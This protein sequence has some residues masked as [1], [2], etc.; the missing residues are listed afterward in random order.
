MLWASITL[1]HMVIDSLSTQNY[2]YLNEIG[3]EAVG[4][5]VYTVI[6]LYTYVCIDVLILETFRW[7]SCSGTILI[8]IRIL[9]LKLYVFMI[10][11]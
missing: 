7:I 8:L 6:L 3:L 5:F 4:M 1:A 2:C 10:K 11:Q 9:H